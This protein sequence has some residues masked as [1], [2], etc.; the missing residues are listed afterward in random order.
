MFRTLADLIGSAIARDARTQ[1]LA[2][3]NRIVENSSTLL[4]RGLP[5]A[6]MPLVYISQNLLRYGYEAASFLKSPKRYIDYV[7]PDDQPALAEAQRRAASVIAQ[8]GTVEFRFKTLNGDYRW[9]ESR[10]NPIRDPSGRLTEIEGVLVDITERKKGEETIAALARTDGLTGLANRRTFLER[11]DQAVAA[12]KR[13]ARQFAVLS[14]DLDHFKEVN[15]TLGHPTGDLLLEAIAERLRKVVRETDLVARFGG[16][17]FMILQAD[18]DDPAAA[19]ALA[20][21]MRAT[22]A[23][24]LLIEGNTLQVTAS[25]GIAAF[26]GEI[27]DGPGMIVQADVALYR[28]KEEGRDRYRFHSDAMNTDVRDRMAM[29]EDMHGAL[30]RHEFEL[31]YQPLV[32]LDSGRIVGMEALVRW[33]HPRRGRL[34][35]GLSFQ[36]PSAPA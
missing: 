17:E 16:D 8:A 11:L 21:K 10:Y 29:V 12:T 7:H 32:E 33:N 34:L 4:F 1:A 36:P 27:G 15:D 25:I 35:P 3:A 24:P 14:L 20:E 23:V 9:I 6:P 28:A 13:G 30:T 18:V 22:V 31:H 2:D 5:Q 26:S 19:G